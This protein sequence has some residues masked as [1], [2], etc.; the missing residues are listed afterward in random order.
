MA[1]HL[2][3]YWIDLE[4]TRGHETQKKRPCVVLQADILNKRT[5]TI[6][7]APLM[8]GHKDWPF[9]VNIDPSKKNGLDIE[10]H[11]NLKQIRGLDIS[12]LDNKQGVLETDYKSDIQEC[13]QLV[14]GM[15]EGF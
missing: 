14:F 11:I 8:P 2:D 1:K 3:I 10:R 9:V 13:L 12:R 15:Q 7:A 4:P 6:L 5:R